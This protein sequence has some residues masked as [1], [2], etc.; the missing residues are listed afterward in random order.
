MSFLLYDVKTNCP[1]FTECSPKYIWVVLVKEIL[2][3]MNKRKKILKIIPLWTQGRYF[4]AL[5]VLLKYTIK[6]IGD[7]WNFCEN[8]LAVLQCTCHSLTA[9]RDIMVRRSAGRALSP[10]AARAGGLQP[11]LLFHRRTRVRAPLRGWRHTGTSVLLF[12]T[13]GILEGKTFKVSVSMPFNVS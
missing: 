12:S 7:I 1:G 6:I 10:L 3:S 5:K 4:W 2:R 13:K 8:S 9:W 11:Q